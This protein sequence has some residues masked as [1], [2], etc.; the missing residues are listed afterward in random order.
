[1]DKNIKNSDVFNTQV[2]F[3]NSR[4]LSKP[5]FLLSRT[6]RMSYTC[7]PRLLAQRKWT[8]WRWW[9]FSS[10]EPVVSGRLQIKPS[11][12]GDENGWWLKWFYLFSV[13]FH[14]FHIERALITPSYI[15]SCMW[16]TSGKSDRNSLIECYFNL[17]LDYSEI[18]SFLL[19]VQYRGGH[20]G[21]PNTPIP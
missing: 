5:R 18:P 6:V 13:S 14:A 16:P 11:G 17:G 9:P 8:R 1:M 19:L 12:S 21:V 7:W 20:W 15:N 2:F 10:P 4:C 3:S